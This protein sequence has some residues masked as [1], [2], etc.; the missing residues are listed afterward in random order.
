MAER[1]DYALAF[2]KAI[3]KNSNFVLCK[4]LRTILK[5]VGVH[6]FFNALV[7]IPYTGI[8]TQKATTKMVIA[9]CGAP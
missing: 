9:F 3:Y 6:C 4:I 7:R 8:I 2:C 5:T 1:G